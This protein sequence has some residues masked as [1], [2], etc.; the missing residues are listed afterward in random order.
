MM[1]SDFHFL[2]PYWLLTLIPL[3]VIFVLIWRKKSGAQAWESVCDSHLLNHLLVFNGKKSRFWPLFLLFTA[4]SLMILALAGPAWQRLPAPTYQTIQAR[5]IVLNLSKSMLNKELTPDRLS[6]AKFK[7]HDLFQR[8]NTG[9]FALIVYTE[10]PFIVSPLT[11]DAQTID[12]LLSMLS[13]DIMP[14]SGNRLALALDE[15]GKLIANAGFHEGQILVMTAETPDKQDIEAAR[16]LAKKQIETSVM[17][18]LATRDINPLYDA[19]A[20]A[21]Q[22]KLLALNDQG[23]DL[24]QWL[25]AGSQTKA[26]NR[27]EYSMIPLWRDEGRW[28]LIPALIFF[29]P[30]F[31]RGWIQRI[32]L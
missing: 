31:R 22:G 20:D 9:Q 23:T 29:I 18:M 1:F 28:F 27:S 6:R 17:P 15:A 2:R 10:E 4:S 16:V 30:V 3:L 24:D 13:P 11:D 7:L 8:S 26:L 14:V 5:V 32:S 12:S 19:L 21:G 25:Q